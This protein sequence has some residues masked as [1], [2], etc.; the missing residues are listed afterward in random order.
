ME[1]EIVTNYE[2]IPTRGALGRYK[3]DSEKLKWLGLLEDH[4]PY[5]SQGI[6]NSF[7]KAFLIQ[8]SSYNLH[9]LAS[10][11]NG[12]LS[13]LVHPFLL[14]SG[15]VLSASGHV[16]CKQLWIVGWSCLPLFEKPRFN[17]FYSPITV[18]SILH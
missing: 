18:T 7:G 12:N 4:V 9:A 17:C 10:S 16:E 5:W 1:D 8:K 14:F 11:T 3:F 15:S 6:V 13:S 2:S